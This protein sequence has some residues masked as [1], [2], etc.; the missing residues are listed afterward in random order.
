[1]LNICEYI[2][3][4]SF[5]A[6]GACTPQ[7]AASTAMQRIISDAAEGPTIGE[8]QIYRACECSQLSF[9]Y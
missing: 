7:T 8:V 9:V 3:H 2:L 4:S 6:P 5:A 1:M